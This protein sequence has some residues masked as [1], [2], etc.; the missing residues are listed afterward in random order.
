MSSGFDRLEGVAVSGE[1]D[2]NTR[3][4]LAPPK[5]KELT[6]ARWGKSVCR[7]GQ[8]CKSVATRKGDSAK[9]MTGFKVLIFKVG[10][11]CWWRIINKTL[12]SPAIPA[13]ASKWP[14]FV[15][16]EP[17]SQKW[18][19]A[20]YSRKAR[21]KASTSIGSPNDVPVPCAST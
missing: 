6:L 15:L 12:M 8:S 20:V 2:S 10:G 19:S 4:A 5:P 9:L 16:T 11:I 21:V 3:C 13:A 17:I 1:N 7:L 18:R 14:I